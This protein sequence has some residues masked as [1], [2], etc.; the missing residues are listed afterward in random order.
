MD[1]AACSSCSARIIWTVTAK[2]KRMPVDAEPREY[3]TFV[4]RGQG[5]DVP[6]LALH[7]SVSPGHEPLYVSHFATC[8]DGD[9]W[10][11]RS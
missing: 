5:D 9:S 1:V 8:P 2:G 7:K 4:L 3:G 11:R 10:R 6:L